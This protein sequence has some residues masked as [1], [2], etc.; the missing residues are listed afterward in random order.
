MQLFVF[1]SKT[2]SSSHLM[3][4]ILISSSVCV[5]YL[6]VSVLLLNGSKPLSL[7]A[8]SSYQ[9]VN[10]PTT[11]E[12]IVFGI[13]S[14]QKSWTKRKE[15]VKLWWK[16]S[17][18]RGCLFLESMPSN[19]TLMDV[20]DVTLPPI[21]ISEDTSRFRYTYRGGLRSAIRVARV[22]SETVALNYPNVRWYVFGDDDTVFFP[23]NLAKTL[24]KYDHRLWYY[25]GAGSEIYEQNRIFGFGMAFGG[26][27]FAI[28]YPLAK[29]LA[30]VF[31]SCIERY[32]HLY[33]SDSRVYSCLTELG[34]GLT[35]EP[36]FH[37][38]DVRGNAFGLL[39]AHPL[40]PLVSL[41][42]IDHIDPIFPNMT[43]S[44]AMQHLL[45]AANVDP[46][47]ILQQTVCYDRWSSWTVSVSWGY[48]IQ[49]YSKPVSLP[50]VLPVP[51]T[52]RQWKRGN[53]LAGVYTFN[54][55][56]FHPHPCQRPT[57]FYLNSVSSTKHGIIE[58]VYNKS[59]EDCT[60][61]M[62]PTR[63]L[64]E[65]RVF[66]KKLDLNHKQMQAPRRHCC[67][68]L[69]SKSGKVLDVAIRECGEDE[70]IYMHA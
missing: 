12:H 64:E 8:Y 35:R 25:I 22:V 56:K 21:C 14:N 18:M 36:G 69:P 40:T 32:P 27:G 33:G 46:Q 57:I 55:K 49:A 65:I 63:K 54:T 43:T 67:D 70:L 29:V 47:R 10:T 61:F 31:D 2:Q 53:V 26:A 39:A 7:R 38:F 13:A 37:Q 9:D 19:A 66:T 23:E 28:S 48:A 6:V 52:F 45:H 11:V 17:Q 59:H 42:H 34:V 20:D 60:V 30:K 4:F 50:D 3:N 5:T 1:I 16:P 44:K 41:H 58:T 15:Y 51:E 24:S 68:V 62:D